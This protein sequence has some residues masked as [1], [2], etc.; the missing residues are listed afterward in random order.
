MMSEAAQYPPTSGEILGEVE[1]PTAAAPSGAGGT[2]DEAGAPPPPY[3]EAVKPGDNQT[4]GGCLI[5]LFKFNS[6][7]S[8][9]C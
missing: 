9:L 4:R 2:G 5:R 8:I 1:V 7:M 6:E 3:E